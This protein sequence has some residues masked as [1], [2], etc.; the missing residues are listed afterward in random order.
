[1]PDDT[2]QYTTLSSAHTSYKQSALLG[3]MEATHRPIKSALNAIGSPSAPVCVLTQ[4]AHG[5]AALLAGIGSLCENSQTATWQHLIANRPSASAT[6]DLS[7]K[8]AFCQTQSSA[9]TELP[10][11]KRVKFSLKQP[12]RPALTNPMAA[13]SAPLMQQALAPIASPLPTT[14]LASGDALSAVVSYDRPACTY[15]NPPV[16][17]HL[18]SRAVVVDGQAICR[19]EISNFKCH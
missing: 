8:A 18:H 14:I 16:D 15:Y 9:V 6:L 3:S 11:V 19:T 1:M 12:D 10:N 7:Q 5:D 13:F 2:L 17:L 4:A